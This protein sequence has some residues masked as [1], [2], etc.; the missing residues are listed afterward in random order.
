MF[1]RGGVAFD[2]PDIFLVGGSFCNGSQTAKVVHF[3]TRTPAIDATVI[4]SGLCTEQLWLLSVQAI[5]LYPEL[6]A[7]FVIS[8]CDVARPVADGKKH[9]VV[10][11]G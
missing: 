11:M 6:T 8:Y 5:Y 2:G 7:F 10:G 1:F 9:L 4:H 3:D